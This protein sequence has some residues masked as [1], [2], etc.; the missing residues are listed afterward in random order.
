MPTVVNSLAAATRASRTVNVPLAGRAYDVLIGP[1]L[2]A[3]AGR[4]IATRLG[5]ARCAIVTDE[6]V[7]ALHLPA[8]E[9][10]LRAEGRNAGSVVLKPGEATKSFRE[11]A[12][13]RRGPCHRQSSF[14]P[15][16]A[17]AGQDRRA[18]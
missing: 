17:C 4:L 2:L 16:G 18:A 10:S 14:A 9:A 7:A 6:N 3:E 1:D 5:K 11:L 12:P 15:S 8:L 13:H